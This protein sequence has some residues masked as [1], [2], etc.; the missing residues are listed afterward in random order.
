MAI[1]KQLTFYTCE[2]CIYKGKPLVRLLPV[3]TEFCQI[4]FQ[5]PQANG[6]FVATIFRRKLV[7]SLK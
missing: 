1:Y 6:H 2:L 4:K 7:N 5:P 3:Q